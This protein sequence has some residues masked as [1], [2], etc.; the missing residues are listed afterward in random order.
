LYNNTKGGGK[1]KNKKINRLVFV[2][3]I[4]LVFLAGA[5]TEN[6]VHLLQDV[7]DAGPR[8]LTPVQSLIQKIVH[9]DILLLSCATGGG[10]LPFPLRLRFLLRTGGR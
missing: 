3:I 7:I 4:F 2:L 6:Q 1:T 5:V 9:K 8:L 10:V